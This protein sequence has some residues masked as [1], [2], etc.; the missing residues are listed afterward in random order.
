M[1]QLVNL[2]ISAS[3]PSARRGLGLDLKT[4]HALGGQS[5]T[6]TTGV[7]LEADG[8]GSRLSTLDVE[9]IG[10]QM[11]YAQRRLSLGS[12]KVGWLPQEEAITGLADALPPFGSVPV[13]VNLKVVSTDEDEATS[14]MKDTVERTLLPRASLITLGCL[15]ASEWSGRSIR[16]AQESER[17]AADLSRRWSVP[18]LVTGGDLHED[19]DAI[20]VLGDGETVRRFQGFRL[21]VE[22]VAG[23]GDCLSTAIA[24]QLGWGATL[25]HAIDEAKGA[26]ARWMLTTVSVG[27]EIRALC[28][29]AE[30]APPSCL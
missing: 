30:S 20:D 5:A 25:A 10:E 6:V 16:T 21:Q 8:G 28:P 1:K 15:E 4:I 29:M 26:V 7:L 11:D 24:A 22:S 19:E 2:V 18:V 23:K 12:I 9:T 17:V 27:P 14:R 3:D 13:V